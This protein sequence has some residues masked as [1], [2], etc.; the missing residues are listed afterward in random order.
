MDQYTGDI[1]ILND[2]I[3]RTLDKKVFI[4]KYEKYL[5]DK[6]EDQDVFEFK[7]AIE[8]ESMC[9]YIWVIF[10]QNNVSRIILENSDSS[11]Q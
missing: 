2:T 6:N 7:D 5:E 3:Y 9:F 11:L 10:T 1:K 8:I 4:N